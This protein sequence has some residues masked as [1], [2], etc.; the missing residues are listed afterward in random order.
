MTDGVTRKVTNKVEVV[1]MP[2]RIVR[3]ETAERVTELLGSREGRNHLS[4][5][6]WA[7]NMPVVMTGA[8]E[9]VNDVMGLVSM[10]GRTVLVAMIDP[11]TD[12]LK[13]LHV[14]TPNQALK[15]VGVEAD[16]T[17]IGSLIARAELEGMVTFRVKYWQHS[18]VAHPIPSFRST[19]AAK[20]LHYLR[21]L[22]I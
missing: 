8:K 13:L 17:Q 2:G 12:E 7:Q 14:S 19:A 10:H 5:Y 21:R 18:A 16:A 9:S 1:H 11:A 22:A 4:S 15:T 3:T 6:G 20:T